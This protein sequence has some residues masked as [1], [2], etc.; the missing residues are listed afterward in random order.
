[1]ALRAGYKGIKKYVAD[2]L[3]KMNPGDTFATDAEIAAA[4]QQ[5]YA[6]MGVIGAKNLLDPNLQT[7]SLLT[8]TVTNSNGVINLNG[9]ATGTTDNNFAIKVRDLTAK[10]IYL[11]KGDY[12]FSAEGIEKGVVVG[13]TYNNAFTPIARNN[14]GDSVK[15]SITDSTRSDYKLNDGSVLIALYITIK[16]GKIYNNQK[17]YP[18]VRL[19]SDTDPTYQPYAETNLQL[20]Q[21]KADI[22][23]LGTQEGAT[24]SRLYHP[25]EHFYKDG[26]FC[27]VI[28]SADVASGS[29]WT[30][31][32]NFVEGDIADLLDVKDVQITP[33]ISYTLNQNSQL[34]KMGRLYSMNA[35]FDGSGVPADTL[36][37]I[38]TI[39]AEEAPS[40][41]VNTVAI[42]V[43]HLDTTLRAYVD[44]NGNIAVRSAKAITTSCKLIFSL[45]W[46]K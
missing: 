23:A 18:M 21:N 2:M 12:I 17:V 13:T 3:N 46:F 14:D 11:P 9:I 19:A 16:A 35:R 31:N 36:T 10:H 30:K 34:K 24:A 42:D 37:V 6:D 33:A 20:T 22:S 28:G 5:I 44:S 32:S 41:V 29:T 25:G 1:M 15:F 26:K 39:P 40:I 4:A 7:G 43:D 38:G 8:V 45:T 27:T